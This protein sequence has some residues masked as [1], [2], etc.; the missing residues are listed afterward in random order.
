MEN[1]YWAGLW[2]PVGLCEIRDIVGLLYLIG[3][4]RSQHESLC[5]LWS[6][7]PLGR[8]IFPAFFGRNW[9]EQVIAN[10]RFD[11]GD[12]NTEDKFAAFRQMWEQF[13]DNCGKHHAVGAF[14]NVDEQQILF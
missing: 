5:S 12:R 14:I 13:I 6:S 1:G 8:A 7:G 4:Y 9:F 11:S 10:L 3:V 2:V